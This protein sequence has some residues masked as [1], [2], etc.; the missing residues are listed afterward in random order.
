MA[1]QGLMLLFAISVVGI[2]LAIAMAALPALAL[3]L[4]LA[5]LVLDRLLRR[6]AGRVTGGVA[7]ALVLAFLVAIAGLDRR[8]QAAVIAD[9]APRGLSGWSS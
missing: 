6:A 9:L 7:V 8:G 1:L 5:R 3:V 2:P 4:I